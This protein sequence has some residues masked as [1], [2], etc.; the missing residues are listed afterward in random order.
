ME[1]QGSL[2]AFL[3]VSLPRGWLEALTGTLSPPPLEGPVLGWNNAYCSDRMFGIFGVFGNLQRA[4]FSLALTS[5]SKH[6]TQD[7]LLSGKGALPVNG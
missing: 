3:V 2:A 5:F 7:K 4:A 1:P 6:V